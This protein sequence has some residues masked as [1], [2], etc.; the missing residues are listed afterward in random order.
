M[1]PLSTSCLKAFPYSLREEHRDRVAA[2]HPWTLPYCVRWS[3]GGRRSK[4]QGISPTERGPGLPEFQAI[5][6]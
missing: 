2:Q 6:H 4:A 3:E 5:T 1:A